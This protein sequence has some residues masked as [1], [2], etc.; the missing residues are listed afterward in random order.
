[1][2]RVGRKRGRDQDSGELAGGS[3]EVLISNSNQ[4]LSLL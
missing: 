2:E 4:T 3:M 1:M